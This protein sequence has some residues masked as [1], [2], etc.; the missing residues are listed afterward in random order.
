LRIRTVKAIRAKIRPEPAREPP[1]P[2]PKRYAPPWATHGEQKADRILSPAEP[3]ARDLPRKTCQRL[4]GR[5]PDCTAALW[6]DQRDPAPLKSV[7]GTG[8]LTAYRDRCRFAVLWRG[9]IAQASRTPCIW[10]LPRRGA[11]VG[12]PGTGDHLLNILIAPR[13]LD[14]VREMIVGHIA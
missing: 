8:S 7:K 13:L 6:R 3:S 12:L 1:P 10:R 9:T 2:P 4:P 11:L 5:P 14:I